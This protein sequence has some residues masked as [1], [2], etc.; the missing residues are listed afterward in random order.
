MRLQI[1]TKFGTSLYLAASEQV[2]HLAMPLKYFFHQITCKELYIHV[3][4]ALEVK[5]YFSNYEYNYVV[6]DG[7]LVCVDGGDSIATGKMFRSD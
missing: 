4:Y 6:G 2:Q 1:T 3:N 5:Y 7:T